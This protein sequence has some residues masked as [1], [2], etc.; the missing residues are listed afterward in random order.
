MLV[1]VLENDI[2][3]NILILAINLYDHV[4]IDLLI[5]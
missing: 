1:F 3:V 5:Q 4:D 2:Y